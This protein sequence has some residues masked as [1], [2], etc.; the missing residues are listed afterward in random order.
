MF[1]PAAP[2]RAVARRAGAQ[3]PINDC[4]ERFMKMRNDK[5]LRHIIGC[6][7]IKI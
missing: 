5:M 4:Y 2:P 7:S 3:R 1:A 6:D